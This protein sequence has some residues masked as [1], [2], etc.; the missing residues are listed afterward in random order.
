MR[1][2]GPVSHQQAF[3]KAKRVSMIG[4]MVSIGLVFV[5][6][7]TSTISG[8][9]G[10][11][12]AP[13]NSKPEQLASLLNPKKMIG[14]MGEGSMTS[15]GSNDS[16]ET[17]VHRLLLRDGISLAIH[18]WEDKRFTTHPNI[19]L[20]LHGLGAHGG[21]YDYFGSSLAG[22]GHL[23]YAVD[24]RG[25]GMSDGPRGDVQN[26]RVDLNDLEEVVTWLQH[27]H[28]AARIYLIGESWGCLIALHYVS[29]STVPVSGI[30]LLSPPIRL[31]IGGHWIKPALAL[32]LE[33]LKNI[34]TLKFNGKIG[35]PFPLELA[36][37][38]PRF[39]EKLK[40]KETTFK[41]SMRYGSL[42]LCLLK[43]AKRYAAQVRVPTLIMLGQADRLLDPR[44]AKDL[45]RKIAATDKQLVV[46]DGAYH[47]LY[48]DPATPSVVE[49]IT[50]W[51]LSKAAVP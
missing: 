12:N 33:I 48:Y 32:T 3:G 47:T 46:V 14:S 9:L 28:P 39:F 45:L 22:A 31:K 41:V 20:I 34:F 15:F 4:D 18:S 43:N 37:R 23:T 13:T 10:K 6:V 8:A 30:I 29:D 50:A 36:S 24:R 40:T 21:Y 11:S 16:V 17:G 44:G 26:S 51:V 42:A 5:I 49:T 1:S 19:F 25:F 2:G 27:K 38:D 7:S 35:A